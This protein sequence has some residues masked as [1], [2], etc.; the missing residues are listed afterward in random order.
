MLV[1]SRPRSRRR[2]LIF[3]VARRRPNNRP[4]PR[5]R[6][7]GLRRRRLGRGPPASSRQAKR[8]TGEV[9][10]L[11]QVSYAGDRRPRRLT[12]IV[13]AI[14]HTLARTERLNKYGDK[15]FRA[16]RQRVGQIGRQIRRLFSP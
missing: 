2:V 4:S 7:F 11:P 16:G 14:R 3:P 6:R 15:V 9:A 1:A 12:F 8:R 10:S 13:A 5:R